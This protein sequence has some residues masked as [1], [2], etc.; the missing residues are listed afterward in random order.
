MAMVDTL[1]PGVST[2]TSLARYYALYWALAAFAEEHQL[3]A[4]ACQTVLRRAEVALALVSREYHDEWR[5]HGIDRVGSILDSG[6]PTTLVPP[7]PVSYSPRAWGFWSQ[8]NGPS[9]TLG[10]VQVDNGALRPGRHPCPPA[11]RQMFRPLLQVVVT[12]D[13]PINDLDPI[14]GLALNQPDSPDVAPLSELFTATR[15]GRHVS[16][17]W[18]GDDR[19]RRE[20]L[21]ILARAVQLRPEAPNW[22]QALRESVA[23]GPAIE[24][25][26]VL[27]AEDRALAWCGVLLRHL[28][29]GAWRRLWADLVHHV[30]NGAGDVT[31]TDLHDWITASLPDL[32]VRA[33]M[34]SCPPTVDQHGHPAPAEEKAAEQYG[35]ADGVSM[36]AEVAILLLGGQ[37]VDQLTGRPLAAFLGRGSRGRG[38]FLDPRWVAYRHREH[39]DRPLAEL[40]RAFVDDMLAQARRVALRKLRVDQTGR[41]T[42]FTR[43]HER[44][45]RY[46]ADQLEGAGNVG[47]RIDQLQTLAEQ[48][49]LAHQHADR[50]EITPLAAQT[51]ELP[52]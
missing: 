48:L 12:R 28:S 35:D 38:Q 10:T 5:A 45:G 26:P 3:D 49:G 47:L 44:N 25:D 33:F 31:R 40:A 43:L 19:T 52:Q 23:Y 11:V 7:G 6:D 36:L 46:F 29:V 13:Y 17:D 8:Y 37:R 1:V 14:A 41:M 2:L 30:R 27:A 21:R 24:H 39:A 32:T 20:T 15:A 42:L 34:R 22:A 50:H 51:L 4:A 16:A 9:V 18:T